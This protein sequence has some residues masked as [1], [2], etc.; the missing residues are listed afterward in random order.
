[1]ARHHRTVAKETAGESPQPEE[2]RSAP[3]EASS[4]GLGR[5]VWNRVADFGGWRTD[6]TY[7][8]PRWLVL[9]AVGIIYILVFAGIIREGQA[10][11]GPT[12]ITPLDAFFEQLK[13]AQPSF[14]RAWFTA[15]SY[16]WFGHGAGAITLLSWAG[17]V[18]AVALVLN[19]WPRM[20]LFACWSLFISFTATWRMFSPAQL[21]GLMIE[22][23]LLCIP[24]APSGFRPGL[25]AHS[26]P[27][28][29]AVF[30][31]RWL[32]FRVM[33]ESGLVKYT[34]G[35][36]H[37]RDLSAMEVMYE[38]S[39]LPTVLAYWDHH[40]PHWWHVGE[41]FLTCLAEIAAP[42]LAMFGGRR[43]RWYAL[44]FWTLFQI[45]IQLTCS[46]G[47]LNT[48]SIGL[49]LVLLDDQ[50]LA[51]AEGKLKRWLPAR[52]IRART[53]SGALPT[54]APISLWRTWRYRLVAAALWVHFS[55]SVFYL[56][57]AAGIKVFDVAPKTSAVVRF[58][59]EFRSVKEYS[60]YAAF[61]P[62]RYQVEFEGS[63]DG[64]V[65]WRPYRYRFLPQRE[66]EMPGFIAPWFGRF[67]AT[68]QIEAWLGRKSPVLPVVAARLLDRQPAVM[69]LFRDDPFADR[70][71]TL[72]RMIGYRMTFRDVA[73]WRQT[74]RYWK[75]EPRGEY[76][77]GLYRTESGEIGQFSLEE[78]TAALNSRDF[79][80]A[81]ESFARQYAAGFLAAGFRLA[82]LELR[83]LGGARNPEGAFE[84]FSELARRGEAGAE[85]SLG[86]CYENGLGVTA[87]DAQAAAHYFRGASQGDMHS[88]LALGAL[89]AA[90][91]ISPR[92]DVEGLRWLLSAERKALQLTPN[93]P[94]AAT[95]RE[96][97][98]VLAAKLKNRMPDSQIK[99]AQKRAVQTP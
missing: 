8:W 68:L 44:L 12:G 75:K 32:V 81:R 42:L 94:A 28:P 92:N 31:V 85:Y 79:A 56:A 41:I 74:G 10:L 70:P 45:G 29:I 62:V 61:D 82:D 90:D 2:R 49:G 66:E 1:M 24:W 87:N 20:A 99:E 5:R 39:P 19:L 50:M 27:R 43:G 16:F 53:V 11:I 38:T 37:W 48:A 78:G 3:A 88:M 95:I 59:S 67:E 96:R 60:L 17:L 83:G 80:G 21:D 63:N 18:S 76:L 93:D 58:F 30:M 65:T 54:P 77:P 47:W 35:D 72:V 22:V 55:F 14:I 7:L 91:R 57:K 86:V 64:G 46:F 4:A 36:P 6:A 98:N 9:R 26:P 71:P 34:A 33:F 73:T 97:E 84:I 69:A 51:A 40:L 23:A 13:A 15:P 89:H 25:G 52:W